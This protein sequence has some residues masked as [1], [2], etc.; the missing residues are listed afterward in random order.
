VL[1]LQRFNDDKRAIC[2]RS[3]VDSA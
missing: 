3:D 1:Y 2:H